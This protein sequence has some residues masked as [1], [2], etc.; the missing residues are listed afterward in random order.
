MRSVLNEA[1]VSAFR[2]WRRA[3]E[4]ERWVPAAR[5]LV[6]VNDGDPVVLAHLSWT[7]QDDTRSALGF[8]PDMRSCYGHRHASGGEVQELRG[9]LD[10][11]PAQD[12]AGARGYEFDTETAD[13]DGWSPAGRLRMLIDDGSEAHLRAAAWSGRSGDACSIVLRSARPAGIEDVGDLVRGVWASAEHRDGGEVATNLVRPSTDKWFADRSRATLE[14]QLTEPIAVDRY[15]LTSADD[16]PDRDPS[17]WTLRGSADGRLWRTLDIRSGQ[18]F[19]G[20]H[21]SG[22]YWIAEPGPYEHYRLDVTGNHGSPHLQLETVQFLADGGSG[23]AGYR[24]RAGR[25]PAPY[26]GSGL[27]QA[28]PEIPAEPLSAKGSV[29]LTPQVP[30]K[31]SPSVPQKHTPMGARAARSVTPG[32]SPSTPDPATEARE[33]EW[34]GWQPGASWLPLGGALSM[35]SLTSP[36]GRFTLLHSPYE[37]WLAVRDNR[38]RG[39]VWISDSPHCSLVCL[40]PDGDLVAWDHRGGR[41]WSTGTAWLGVR[42]LELRDSG[43][44]ALTGADGAVVWSSGI[45]VVPAGDAPRPVPRGSVLRRGESL[46]GQSLTSADGSTVLFHDGRVVR[47]IVRG[48]TSHWDRFPETDTVLVLDDD[49]FLRLR[50]LD[51]AVLEQ[52]AGP[53]A[54]L[55]VV[56]GAV[57]LRDDA[58]TVVWASCPRLQRPAPVR[59]QGLAHNAD[60]VAW[61]AALTGGGHCVAV[62]RG[63]TPREVL[64]RTGAT[65]VTGTW[66]DLQ[67]H[68]DATH[69]DGG[70]VVAAIAVGPDVLLVADD[71]HLPVATLA[72]SVAAVHQPDAQFGFAVFSVHRDGTLVTELREFPYRRKG[73]KV[74]EV[75]AALEEIV[76]SLHSYA[77]LFRTAGVVPS[78]AGLGGELLGGVL[79]PVPEPE[80]ALPAEPLLMVQGWESMT[81]LVVRTDF[82]DEDAWDRVIQELRI[83]WVDDEPV[84]PYLIS[85]PRLAGAPAEQVLREVCAAL[86]EPG[87]PGA[88]FIA[89]GITMREPGHP[90]LAVTTEWDGHP[91]E[92]D[93]EEFITQFRLLPDAAVEV[94]T[95][96]DL[97]NMDFDDFAGEGVRERMA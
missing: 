15:V 30:Q 90:L 83:P 62:V 11:R 57:E 5:L 60:L 87:T 28:P 38:T 56:R 10:D 42:R 9:E 47:I 94:S 84:D 53:G 88:V 33:D 24:G 2:M 91:F 55:V 45:P 74:P 32:P 58:G 51:G 22:T 29:L 17:A 20:R 96:L 77:L 37:P 8:A 54:E 14:F 3:W 80:P 59:A 21:R 82:T 85:D 16:A 43:E 23:F 46:D 93:E 73:T 78:A 79:A 69:P 70:T 6:H 25:A 67:R 49:G 18:S 61:F 76:H 75:A 40:G 19:A 65:P 26:R 4:S 63:S 81:P 34:T 41:V 31:F 27:L 64:G 36:S 39:R 66:R 97:G 1:S 44:L 50:H 7:T 92:D 13:A 52:I 86:P 89:D 35:Q 72:A 95:N 71:P 68:R 48:R 12:A